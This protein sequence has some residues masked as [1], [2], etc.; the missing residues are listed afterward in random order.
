MIRGAAKARL[1][2]AN[3]DRDMKKQ[4]LQALVGGAS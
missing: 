1:E 2:E 4:V 3:G